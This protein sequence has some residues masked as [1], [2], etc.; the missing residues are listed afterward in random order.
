MNNEDINKLRD[1]KFYLERFCKIKTK[2]RGMEPFILNEAQK[3]IFNTIRKHNRVIILKCRQLGFSTGVT[4]YFYVDTIMNPGTTTV[5]VG[6]NNEMITEL[7][8]KIKTFY[9]TTP[10]NMRPT[11]KYD[12]RTQMSFPKIDSKIMVLPCTM[13]VG[14]GYTIHNLLCLSGDV[15]ILCKNGNAKK[16]KE[17]SDG[18]MIMNSNGGYSNI[19]KLI[20]RKNYKKIISIN[21]YNYFEVQYETNEDEIDEKPANIKNKFKRFKK[22]YFCMRGP[23]FFEMNDDG[24]RVDDDGQLVTPTDFKNGKLFEVKLKKKAKMILKE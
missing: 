17:L 16:I 13:D 22:F 3:D 9:Q 11:I 8:D 15:R 19:D 4:G 14:R 24:D 12:S 2:K 21:T 20:K 10:L 6:Y 23:E 5:L 7:L 1:P 18:E